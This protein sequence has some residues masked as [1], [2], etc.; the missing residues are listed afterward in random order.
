M[1]RASESAV[2]IS[3]RLNG[4][5]VLA[6]IP[7]RLSLVDMLRTH[8]RLTGSHV[9]C[10]H[11]VCGACNVIHDGSV[12]RGCLTLAVQADGGDIVTIEGLTASGEIS[13]LQEAFVKRNALQCGFCTSG[14]LMT[15][16]ELLTRN[17][18]PSRAQI[19]EEVSG[20]YCRCTG[21]QAI[22]DAIEGVAAGRSDSDEALETADARGP[23]GA[24]CPRPSAARLASGGGNYT[25][26]I[27]LPGTG[28]VAFLRSPHAHARVVSIDLT[29]ALSAPGVIAA[30]DGASLAARCP[31]WQTRLALMP[32]H[33]SAPQPAL[34]LGESCWQGEA[35]AAVVAATRAQAEDAVGLIEVEWEALPVVAD[36]SSALNGDSPVVHSELTNNLALDHTIASGD[37]ANSFAEAAVIVEHAFRF[38][39]QTAVSL[40]PRSIQASFDRNLGELTVYQSHQAPFQMREIFAEQL[41][42]N[43][44]KVRVVVRDVG[45]GFGLKLHAFADE[46]AVVAIATL[47]P[48]PVKFTADRLEAFT[49]DAHTRD[50]DARGRMAFDDKGKILG[51][52]IDLLV[53]FGAYSIYPR[54]SAGEA[55][56]AVQMIGAAYQVGAFNGHVRGVFQNKPPTG[57][58]RGVGQPIACTITEQLLDLGAAALKMDPVELRRLNYRRTDSAIS[59]TTNGIVI[60]QLSLVTCLDTLL[61][62]MNYSEQRKQQMALR[63]TGIL[64]GI[65]I[66]T[67]I[68][69]TGVGSALY[70]SQGL[71]VAANESCR[72][73]LNSTGSVCCETSITDQGQGTATGI[74]QI[75]AGEL[76]IPV[77]SIEVVTGDT[78]MVPYGGGA[79]AS[80]GIALGGEA[81][82]RAALALR[83]NVLRIAASLLQQPATSLAIRSGSI[84]NAVGAEQM[85]IGEIAA[86]SYYRP[87]TIPLEVLPP[88]EV[89]A[90]YVPQS[91]PYIVANG[92]QAALVEI[93]AK[94]GSIDIL[95][96]LIAEDCGRIINPLLVDEQLRGGVVQGIGAALYEQCVYSNEGQ[97]LNGSLADYI[98]PMASEMP[99]IH[100]AHVKTPTNATALG[101]KGV[102]EAGAVGA[103]AAIWTAVN[104]ALRPLGIQVNRQPITPEQ[105]VRLLG[106]ASS[107]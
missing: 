11:G 5:D 88:L 8:F 106:D 46:M 95:D 50:A 64:R 29:A 53:G 48:I 10:E 97:L 82:R 89:V 66:A 59:R 103:P 80:R 98:V 56:Q 74:A 100:I 2:D 102:G 107:D 19:R 94:T 52:E 83:D 58:Y 1:T 43:P 96:F 84:V 73:T 14:M 13:K 25:D 105:V 71:R 24:S 38:E 16:W 45:G 104:D 92:V 26:D 85:S 34:A 47:L 35:I 75:V 51:I 87:H 15:A 81:A 63:S 49:S 65:G 44:E 18:K 17:A 79:W 69:V 37:V 27:T 62:R 76:G 6:R 93:D 12:V 22:V 78:A 90:S 28:H 70:G 32:S 9:G 21:Y 68:E 77:D 31:P 20:N 41:G 3:F 72:L 39:R 7:P 54:S 55:I 67:F 91:V 40:E 57:A 60:E 42:L 99:D 61:R 30:F 4:A 86:A 36:V 23:I 101:S 33:R